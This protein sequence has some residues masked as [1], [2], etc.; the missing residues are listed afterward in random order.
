MLVILDNIEF[1]GFCFLL[2]VF[3]LLYGVFG[4]FKSICY[5]FVI[6]GNLYFSFNLIFYIIINFFCVF[7]YKIVYYIEKYL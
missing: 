7:K 6:F 1:G 4:Y 3:L 2:V 5:V